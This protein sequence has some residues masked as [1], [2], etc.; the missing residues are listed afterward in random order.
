M[1]TIPKK[2]PK[3]N[4]EFNKLLDEFILE[5]AALEEGKS[6]IRRDQYERRY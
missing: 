3:D 2:D 4:P 5:V 6:I 1:N